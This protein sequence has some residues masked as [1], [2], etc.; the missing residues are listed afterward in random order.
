MDA[1]PAP[2][3]L[4]NF[5][6]ARNSAR[7]LFVQVAKTLDGKKGSLECRLSGQIQCERTF[8]TM[9]GAIDWV[10]ESEESVVAEIDIIDPTKPGRLA[11]AV[12][13]Y[14]D[15]SGNPPHDRVVRI[16]CGGSDFTTGGKKPLALRQGRDAYIVFKNVIEATHPSY[17]AITVDYEMETP[18]ELIVDSR[19]HAFR[20]F[21]IDSRLADSISLSRLLDKVQPKPYVESM[22][23]GIYVSSSGYFNPEGVSIDSSGARISDFISIRLAEAFSVSSGH[24]TYPR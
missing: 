8:A 5:Y 14:A 20:D 17:A 23:E 7:D 6:S 19:S 22:E 15:D 11:H 12:L 1:I 4:L 24:G 16:R 21:Y 3:L 13:G 2:N 10:L 18:C 9:M